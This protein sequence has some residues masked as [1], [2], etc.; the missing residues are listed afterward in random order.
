M[1]MIALLTV[2]MLMLASSIALAAPPEGKGKPDKNVSKGIT[3]VKV[4]GAKIDGDVLC[5]I[6]IE[7]KGWFVRA[8]N[9]GDDGKYGTDDSD[10]VTLSEAGWMAT[11]FAIDGQYI[12]WDAFAVLNSG[13][14]GRDIRYYDLGTDLIPGT[15]DDGGMTRLST[16]TLAED[17]PS[18]YG[19]MIV[20]R[21]YGGSTSDGVWLYDIGEEARTRLTTFGND[22]AIIDDGYMGMCAYDGSNMKNT[23]SYLPNADYS[24]VVTSSAVAGLDD[25]RLHT[26]NGGIAVY[27]QTT[28]TGTYS[29]KYV[30]YSYD[31]TGG[32]TFSVTDLWE[33]TSAVVP[34]LRNYGQG[35]VVTNG[36]DIGYGNLVAG[37]NPKA[38]NMELHLLDL[39]TGTDTTLKTANNDIYYPRDIDD[40]WLVYTLDRVMYMYDLSGGTH[41]KLG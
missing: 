14:T 20:Y 22:N 23:F 28:S 24:T 31:T 15:D 1:M 30:E 41:T 33:D 25:Y 11:H 12:A 36:D 7:R 10:V 6:N 26:M 34:A 21:V 17:Q 3:D 2:V 18:V 29:W 35:V 32:W 27:Y 9:L 38:V 19:D 37:K 40:T 39:D 16:P 8:I 5:W 13:N 4:N